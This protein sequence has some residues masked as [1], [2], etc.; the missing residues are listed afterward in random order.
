MERIT[1]ERLS[2]NDWDEIYQ[3]IVPFDTPLDELIKVCSEYAFEGRHRHDNAAF[4]GKIRMILR[5]ID[6][7]TRILSD[8]HEGR[9]R[10]S[11]ERAVHQLGGSD[12]GGFE[13][14][15][16]ASDPSERAE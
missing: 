9:Q 2:Q 12:R 15:C 8:S 6:Y 14:P 5:G 13:I 4:K 16:G 11:R 3:D 10:S 7:D 1:L